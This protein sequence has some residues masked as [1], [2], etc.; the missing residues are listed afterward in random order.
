LPTVSV[1]VPTHNRSA[2]LAQT[3]ASVRAQTFAD[4]EIV[5]VDDG[6]SDNTAEIVTRIDD[7]RVRMVRHEQPL[8]V[9]A[10]RNRGIREA[11]GEWVAFLDD[12]DLWAPSKIARQI[13][14]AGE[15]G[16]LW[17]CSGS[18]T[19]TS[20][21]KVIAGTAPPLAED[22]AVALPFRNTV[23]AGASNVA[24]RVD[25]LRQAGDFDTELRHMSDWDMWIRFAAGGLPAVVSEP[26][27]AYRLHPGNA[28]ADAAELEA[29]I[30][31]IEKRYEANRNGA[32]IDRA[33]ALRWAAWNLLRIGR[34]GAALRAY[35]SAVA[36]GDIKSAARGVV[37]MVDPF[38]VERTLRRSLD[39]E[40]AARAGEWLTGI[41]R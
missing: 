33:F 4:L 32:G 24:V 15:A 11:S 29:E 40:W 41:E 21:M 8:G 30:A 2:L 17:S 12:D 14:A 27:V 35:G 6:S 28:S 16:R 1:V 9:S 23:P 39:P 19:V 37:A 26:D 38:V 36:A 10:A 13:T 3:L 5:V 31:L 25:L 22:I 18:I 7:S 34:R 20:D